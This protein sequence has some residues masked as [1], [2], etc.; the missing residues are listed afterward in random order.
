VTPE[1]LRPGPPPRTF[2]RQLEAGARK[3]NGYRGTTD[4]DLEGAESVTDLGVAPA[5]IFGRLMTSCRM[6]PALRGLPVDQPAPFVRIERGGSGRAW[7]ARVPRMPGGR[8]AEIR[9]TREAIRHS[10][11]MTG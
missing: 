9:H 2:R 6:S 10:V 8:G 7:L 4:F 1:E 3:D 5:G 11:N